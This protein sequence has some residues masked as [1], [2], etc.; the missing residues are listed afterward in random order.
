[1][2]FD[3][4]CI[5]SNGEELYWSWVT[6]RN[7]WKLT[8]V[9]LFPT[10]HSQPC[11][12][13]VSSSSIAWALGSKMIDDDAFKLRFVGAFKYLK[14]MKQLQLARKSL[15]DPLAWSIQQLMNLNTNAGQELVERD[16]IISRLSSEL[17]DKKTSSMNWSN[18]GGVGA[19]KPKPQLKQPMMTDIRSSQAA[20]PSSTLPVIAPRVDWWG[21]AKTRGTVLSSTAM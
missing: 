9:E 4:F 8:C 21:R 15:I 13:R 10:I 12:G 19:F 16:H 6:Q 1:M 18:K 20:D 7:Y 14:A 3:D 17:E 11:K 2:I 5:Q